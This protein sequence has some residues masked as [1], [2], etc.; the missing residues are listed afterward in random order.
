MKIYWWLSIASMIYAG[1]AAAQIAPGHSGIST[2]TPINNARPYRE[3]QTFGACLAR[4]RRRAALA[5]IATEPDSPEETKALRGLVYGEHSTCLLSG[6]EMSMPNVFARGAVAE[7]LLRTAGGVPETY[8]LP[9]PSP[10]EVR[11]LHGAARCYTSSHR[12]EVEKLL[13]TSPGTREEVT[14]VA[15]LWEGLKT[16]MPNLKV[17]LNAPWIRFLLAE[18]LLRLGPSTTSSER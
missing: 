11:D 6:T 13:Q 18:A 5:L 16:C 7:G 17:R 1:E 2:S 15:A 14:A 8:R 3:L 10:T 4:T 12:T 9:S